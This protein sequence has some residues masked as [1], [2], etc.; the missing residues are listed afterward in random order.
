MKTTNLSKNFFLAAV[1]SIICL[2]AAWP[3]ASGLESKYL[4]G[5]QKVTEHESLDK[6]LSGLVSKDEPGLAAAV[7]KNGQPAVIYTAGVTDIKT[8]QPIT[9]KTNFR[10]ASVTKQFTA[11]AVMLLARDGRLQY[12]QSLRDYFP[13]FPAYGQAITIRHLLTHTS[14]LPDY[15]DLLPPAD[16]ARTIE[17][18]Q[19]TDNQ[20][21]ELL[22]QQRRG[23][24][25][26]GEE[27]RYS[28][29]GYVLLGLI[30]EKASGQSF[31]EF[32][33]HRIFAPLGME[34]TVLYERNKNT[35]Q[36]R[37]YGHTRVA[38][39]WEIQD[40]SLTSATRGDGRIYSSVEDLIK[41]D[42]AWRDETLLSAEEKKLALTPVKVRGKGPVDPD[43]RPAAYGFG[44]FLNPW[45]GHP[46]AWHYGETTGF[47]TTIQRFYQDSLTVIILANRDDL[48]PS[49][50]A[51]RLA[52]SFLS[53]KNR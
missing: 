5:R 14:G 29:S 31:D 49:S 2:I 17:E 42:E 35:V 50:L 40:Q 19:I 8:L 41:W 38:G 52:R 37:A 4:R 23:K 20:V 10:L 13:D 12:D 25:R 6:Y 44:W 16:P 27:W 45:E 18:Q 24:F 43:G 7:I 47:R 22:K 30:I 15:E 33:H 32:L 9:A 11:C 48:D 53:S 46:R 21:L 1:I 39:R 34:T 28:N 51:L 3:V 26:A 36:N